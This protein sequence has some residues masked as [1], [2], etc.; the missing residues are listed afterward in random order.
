MSSEILFLIIG[1]VA[2]SWIFAGGL[3]WFI[4]R[5]TRPLKLAGDEFFGLIM[6]NSIPQAYSMTSQQFQM[7]TTEDQFRTFLKDNALVYFE[8]VLWRGR[9]ILN[10]NSA[11]LKGFITTFEKKKIPVR[12]DFIRESDQWKILNITQ[13]GVFGT[14]MGFR[15]HIHT[16]ALIVAAILLATAA[17]VA[18]V[19]SLLT[20]ITQ[21]AESF[22]QHIQKK[23]T[24]L[25][26][27]LT[28]DEFQTGMTLPEFE[29]LVQGISLH[30]YKSVFWSRVKRIDSYAFLQGT[31]TVADDKKISVKIT[32]ILKND[33]WLV[34]AFSLE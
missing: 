16:I 21:T 25:A 17:I 9:R 31:L 14:T 12:L 13:S 32:L 23:D 4:L 27:R 24:P 22:F 11:F 8:S 26:Y 2:V 5:V 6:Q 10:I 1:I 33:Q 34:H 19:F 20:P 29:T 28:S 7:H 15:F 3:I 30:T 18:F